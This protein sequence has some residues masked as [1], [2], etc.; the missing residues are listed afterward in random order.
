MKIATSSR[1]PENGEKANIA[2]GDR[3]RKTAEET[4]AKATVYDESCYKQPCARRLQNA[5]VAESDR[6]RRAAKEASAV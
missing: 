3:V 1:V 2:E 4:L 6:V 5:T